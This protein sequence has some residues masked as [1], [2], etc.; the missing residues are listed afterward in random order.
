MSAPFDVKGWCPGAWRPMETGDGWLV[1]VRPPLGELTRAQALALAQA[2]ERFGSGLIELTSRANVQ[3]R[4]VSENTWP[5]LMDFLV[6]HGLAPPSAFDE[7]R[8]PLMLSP[9]WRENDDTHRAARRLEESD[10]PAL[11]AKVG[12]ALDAG[13]APVL[14]DAP[15][16][17][18]I[19]RDDTGAL[20]VRCEGRALGTRIESA[21]AAA[22]LVVK[23]CHWFMESGGEQAKRIGRHRAPLPAW[24]QQDAAP[25]A[26]GQA[27]RLGAHPLGAVVGLSLGR[28]DAASLRALV[29]PFKTCRLR[30]TPWRRLLVTGAAAARLPALPG[31]ITEPGDPRLSMDAC[32]GAPFCAQAS[33]DTHA[34]AARLS[35]HKTGSLHVSGCAKGCARSRQAAV[36]L[37]G[38]GG[39]FDV[40][41]NDRADGEPAARG[42]TEPDVLDYLEKLGALHL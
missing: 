14:G 34:M 17:F 1:R 40:L 35:H 10:F 41:I 3:L 23:L 13:V 9:E 26:Q 37:T 6:E 33:V 27:L 21:E 32:P 2:S 25:M 28:V 30:V 20:L 18:R 38:R 22:H 8:P 16:D 24:A 7:R 4:G 19:E 11:P 29:T 31:V 12:I 15:A 39:R 5:A 42:L 36:C